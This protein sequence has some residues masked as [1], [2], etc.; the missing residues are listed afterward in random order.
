MTFP[1]GILN[2]MGLNMSKH[3]YFLITLTNIWVRQKVPELSDTDQTIL[4][5][6]YLIS[7]IVSPLILE[8]KYAPES[9]M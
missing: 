4:V 9:Y 1:H 7:F 3:Q 5:M 2:I 6:T 8:S